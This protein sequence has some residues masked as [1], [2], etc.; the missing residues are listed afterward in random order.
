MSKQNEIDFNKVAAELASAVLA[1]PGAEAARHFSATRRQAVYNLA[2]GFMALMFPGC[3]GSEA[4][5]IEDTEAYV[6]YQLRV[7]VGE[8]FPHL[9]QAFDLMSYIESTENCDCLDHSRRAVAHLARSLPAIRHTLGQDVQAAYEGD[10][11]ARSQ[12]EVVLA[13]PFLEAITV[14]RIAHALYEEDVPVIPR[15]MTEWA[16]SRTGI[17]IHPGAQLGP[18]FFID[19]GTGVVIGETTTIG[20]NVRVYQGVTLGALSFPLDERGNP[21]KGVKRHPDIEDDVIIY[22]G[23]TILGGETVVGKGSVIGGNVWL[24]H[25]V[26]PYTKVYNVQP[27][28]KL[29]NGGGSS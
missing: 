14:Q 16:H 10:P 6:E 23:A 2:E 8:L 12:G 17:D 27:G 28:P 25:S 4:V 18:R 21:I 5:A 1:S 29:V 3:F 24:T 20:S 9:R 26:A 19:H 7:L 13:Y 15:M 22:A 11:A